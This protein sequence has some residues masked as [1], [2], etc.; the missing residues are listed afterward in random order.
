M[1]RKGIVMRLILKNLALFLVAFLITASAITWGQWSTKRYQMHDTYYS[2]LKNIEKNP[3]L[4]E[5]AK[6]M[7]MSYKEYAWYLTYKTLDIRPSYLETIK[8]YFKDL[9]NIIEGKTKRWGNLWKYAR[10]TLVIFVIAETAVLLAG[11][12]LGVRAG[13]NGGKMEKVISVVTPFVSAIPSWF[14]GTLVFLSMWDMGYNPDFQMRIQEA[15]VKNSLSTTTY[16]LAYIPPVIVVFLTMVFEYAFIV[17]NLVANEKTEDH[18]TAD[19]AK[20]L[21]DGKIRRKIL[22]TAIS[23]FL[24]YTTYNMLEAITTVLV[25]ELVFEVKGMGYLLRESFFVAY[26]PPDG[27]FLYMYPQLLMFVSLVIMGMYFITSSILETVYLQ[28]DPRISR[29]GN[30]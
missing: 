26:K 12:Y 13:Y 17:M 4:Q 1:A 10:N 22:K 5:E 23:K 7:G 27:I 24:T 2:M 25:I 9:G 18:I 15:S 29:G 3:T 16:L 6:K 11:L 21:P 8:G 19:I 28:L 14:I 30:K 20:G